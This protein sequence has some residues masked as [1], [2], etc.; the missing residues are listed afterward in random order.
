[1]NVA[2]LLLARAA[3]RDREIAIRAALGAGRGRLIRQFLTESWLLALAGGAAGS[4]LGIVGRRLLVK[5]AAD[6]VPRAAEVGF[7]WRVF[8]FLLAICAFTGV[9]FGLAPAA[10][11]ARGG[12]AALKVRGVRSAVRDGLVV[13]EIALAFVLLAGA[14][15]L[16]RTFLNLQRTDPGFRVENVLTAHLVLSGGREGMAIEERVSQIPGVRAAGFVSMLPLQTSGWTAG[17]N[18]PGVSGPH[19]CELRYVTPGYFRAMGIPLRRGREFNSHDAPDSP[20]VIIVNDTLAQRYFPNEDPIGRKLDRGEIIGVAGAVKQASLGGPAIPEIFY[21]VAQNF[22]QI[23]QNGSTLVV[24]GDVSAAGIRAAIRDVSPR[25]AL[26]SIATMRQVV[27]R[28]IGT[29][30]LYTWLMGVFGLLGA[31]LAAAGI[32]GVIGYIVA[33]RTREFGIRMALGSDP[34][35]VLRLVQRQGVWMVMLGL[36]IGLA[37]AAALTRLLK[38]LLYGVAAMDPVT[39]SATAILLAAAALAACLA[40]AR[41]AARV[42]PAV[43]LR[44][45]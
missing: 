28:S 33:L 9:A 39:F 2:N 19:P 21:A 32:Y 35:G 13:A 27:E 10:S 40:P 18:I 1:M 34:A 5:A 36:A 8:V 11:T 29:P 17:F 45:E 25:Q 14:G 6:Q 22:A 16:L 41:R 43:T 23:R 12:S 30:R 37:A 31:I 7:D 15:L 3:S 44:A 38:G 26:F 24:R 20:R 42:D 4:A